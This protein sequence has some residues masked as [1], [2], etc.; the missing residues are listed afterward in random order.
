MNSTYQMTKQ[1]WAEVYSSFVETHW[2]DA[3]DL[4]ENVIVVTMT[5]HPG[6][7]HNLQQ[8]L[9]RRALTVDAPEMAGRELTHP[10]VRL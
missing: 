4:G 5:G 7:H 2:Q 9:G 3:P 1:E 6:M 8:R 10:L